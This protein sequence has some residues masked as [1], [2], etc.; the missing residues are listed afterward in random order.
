MRKFLILFLS[1]AA[2]GET[3]TGLR[4]APCD[5]KPVCLLEFTPDSLVLIAGGISTDLVEIDL[6]VAPTHQHLSQDQRRVTVSLKTLD[7]DAFVVGYVAQSFLE[8]RTRV[9]MGFGQMSGTHGR[10]EVVVASDYDPSVVR[11]FII[12]VVPAL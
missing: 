9:Q 8:D 5:D 10:T 6:V 4:E 12:T 1:L 11:R 7:G 2:C 3:L